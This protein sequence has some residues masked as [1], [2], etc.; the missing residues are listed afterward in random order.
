MFRSDE[1]ALADAAGVVRVTCASTRF[2]A[3]ISLLKRRG[4]GVIA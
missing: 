1:E 2:E 3:S 4:R